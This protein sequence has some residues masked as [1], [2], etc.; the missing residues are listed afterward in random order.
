MFLIG[1]LKKKQVLEC[2][3][4]ASFQ[5]TLESWAPYFV[6][7]L[8][9]IVDEIDSP[10]QREGTRLPAGICQALV[11]WEATSGQGGPTTTRFP[12]PS[13]ITSGSLTHV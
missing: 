11:V 12:L 3:Q 6:T 9:Y 8:E 1:C 5:I 2:D 4:D 10:K 13:A 7:D